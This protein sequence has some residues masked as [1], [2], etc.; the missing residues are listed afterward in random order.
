[1]EILHGQGECT[2]FNCFFFNNSIPNTML[3]L[4]LIAFVLGSVQSVSKLFEHYLES[5][6]IVMNLTCE[7]WCKSFFFFFFFCKICCFRVIIVSVKWGGT[8]LERGR[9][10]AGYYKERRIHFTLISFLTW[11][12]NCSPFS[13]T[14]SETTKLCLLKKWAQKQNHSRNTSKCEQPHFL[15]Q[16]WKMVKFKLL[17]FN[18]E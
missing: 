4:F 3:K 14:N 13:F 8:G 17:F 10:T 16:S 18:I 15:F 7:I 11:H 6:F 12:I 9:N 5:K 1:M 2:F